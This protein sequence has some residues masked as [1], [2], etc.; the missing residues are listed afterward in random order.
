[1][2][3]PRI[4][5]GVAHSEWI[6]GTLSL[7]VVAAWLVGCVVQSDGV[8]SPAKPKPSP[9]RPA[10]QTLAARAFDSFQKRDRL[11]AE[12]LRRVADDVRDGRLKYDGPVMEAIERAGAD[13][14]RETWQPVADA[15]SKLLGSGQTLDAAKCE[16]AIRELADGA[17]KAGQ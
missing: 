15:L 2:D 17:E 9:K 1:M 14:S 4:N 5:L 12:K 8:V 3:R 13:A 11:R 16:Q 10:D 6:R 7:L